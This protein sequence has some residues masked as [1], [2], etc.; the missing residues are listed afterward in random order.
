MKTAFVCWDDRIAPVFDS[1][2]AMRVVE[3]EAAD[4][5]SEKQE[6]LP[7]H[8]PVQR[9]LRLIELGIGT[10]VCGAI[11]R[12]MHELLAAYG[13]AVVPFVAGDLESV[14]RAW[15]HGKLNNAAFAMPG[16][17]GRRRHQTV[18]NTN[19]EEHAM[20]RKGQ[21]QGGAGKGQGGA[22]KGQG[23]GGKGQ[24]GAG[25]GQGG[26]GQGQGGAGRGRGRMG[27]PLAAGVPGMCTCPACG[28]SEPHERGVP[29]VEKRCPKCSTALT[30]G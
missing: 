15:L 1:A 25:Q 19:M 18:K 6:A 27:G 30:R 22:G 5:V 23:R 21:G 28:Y 7:Q 24:G 9:A 8:L 2:Q 12:Q 3:S 29:C 11:S 4:I 16:C 13:I 10:V 17:C 26:A 20:N 14:I